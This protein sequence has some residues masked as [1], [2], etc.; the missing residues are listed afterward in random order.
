MP[1]LPGLRSAMLA[2]GLSPPALAE[3]AGLTPNAVRSLR[4]LASR[5]QP[6][7]L[8]RLAEGLGVPPA[9]LTT[10]PAVELPWVAIRRPNR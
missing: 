5:A 7:T 3:R 10:A 6:S 9:V 8:S 2:A 1:Y 4:N